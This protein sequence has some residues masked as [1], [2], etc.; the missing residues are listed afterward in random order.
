MQIWENSRRDAVSNTAQRNRE[1]DR[2]GIFDSQG[3]LSNEIY[4]LTLTNTTITYLFVYGIYY[5][6]NFCYKCSLIEES[7]KISSEECN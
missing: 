6:W 1:R 2:A 3:D 4:V 7:E 5:D